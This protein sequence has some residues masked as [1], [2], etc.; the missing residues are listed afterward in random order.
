MYDAVVVGL[1]AMGSATAWQLARRGRKVLE[2][3]PVRRLLFRRRR[4]DPGGLV[5]SNG[6]NGRNRAARALLE[7]HGYAAARTFW[8]LEIALATPPAVPVWPVGIAVRPCATDADERAAFAVVDEAMLDHWGHVRDGFEGWAS[9]R[10]A[11]YGFDPALWH[12]ATAG[13]EPVGAA[14]TGFEGDTGWV[15]DLAVRRPW[16]GRGLGR[17]LLLRALGEFHRRG[18]PRVALNVD[19]ASPT[20]ATRLY[21]GVG[22]TAVDEYVLYQKEIR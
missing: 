6:I 9:G 14:I 20:G 7:G 22:M 17:A 8:R 11:R 21:V 19:S 10:K 2:Q 16:R 1:G 5:V 15:R 3:R 12:L 18:T 4:S 13:D